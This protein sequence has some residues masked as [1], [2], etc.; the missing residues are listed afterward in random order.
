MEVFAAHLNIISDQCVTSAK[1]S[2]YL[3]LTSCYSLPPVNTFHS[4]SPFIATDQ[5]KLSANFR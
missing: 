3:Y 1:Y 2:C 4:E 5:N